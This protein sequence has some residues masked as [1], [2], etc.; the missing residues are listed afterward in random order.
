MLN[1]SN[2][3]INKHLDLENF[4]S[5][6]QVFGKKYFHIF[7]R[8]LL[9]FCGIVLITLF[10]PWTQNI[11]G[12]GYVT[13]LT[14]EHR[15]QTIQSQ[16]PGRIE[17]W[18]V[19]EGALVAKGD[20]ILKISEIKSD[21]FDDRLL[22]RTSQQINAKKASSQAYQEKAGALTGQIGA[23]Q[24]EKN[25][26][27]NQARNKLIQ[28]RLQVTT[29]SINRVAA[30]TNKRIAQTRYDRIEQLKKEGLKATRDL[31]EKRLKLQETEA[32]LTA[33][34]NKLMKN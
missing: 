10:L 8:F 33:E 17:Q 3:S 27:L 32:V 1:I 2:N 13:T 16:I 7:N 22:E 26:K 14:P 20:T 29:D 19:R 4:K 15:P 9:I 25:I 28:A 21:Y 5:G 24:R 31:E 34:K 18:F 30:A 11:T 6:K 23:L 12:R